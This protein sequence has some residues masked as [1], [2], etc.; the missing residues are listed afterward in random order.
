MVEE[1]EIKAEQWVRIVINLSPSE[2]VVF[3]NDE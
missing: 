2:T 1:E 3:L